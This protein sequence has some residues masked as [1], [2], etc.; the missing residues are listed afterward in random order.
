M[1][2]TLYNGPAHGATFYLPMDGSVRFRFNSFHATGY[3]R[4]PTG[5]LARVAPGTRLSLPRGQHTL[6]L[7]DTTLAADVSIVF[8]AER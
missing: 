3:V 1:T 6:S 8:Q 2:E 5:A 4:S 7:Y